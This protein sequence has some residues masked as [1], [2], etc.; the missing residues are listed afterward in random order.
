MREALHRMLFATRLERRLDA[1]VAA[2]IAV[3]TFVMYAAGSFGV[4]GG[5]VFLPMD[6]TLVGGIAAAGIG[7]RHGTLLGAWVTLFAA[8]IAFF[9]EWAFLGLSSQNLTGKLAFL[10]DPVALGLS[11]FVAVVLGTIAFAVGYVGSVGIEKVF[12]SYSRW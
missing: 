4:D 11:A 1:L 2:V 9:A 10:F 6:A 8:Y 5:V 7:Y 3:S 12:E